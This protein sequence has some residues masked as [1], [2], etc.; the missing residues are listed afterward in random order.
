MLDQILGQE[1][2]VAILKRA[3][4]TDSLGHAYLFSGDEGVGKETVAR[5]VAQALLK[6]GGPLSELHVLGGPESIK[7]DQIRAVRQKAALAASGS[8]VWIILDAERLTPEAANAFLK[9]LE[10]P[11]QGTY[12]FLT[13]TKVQSILPTI[14]S[15]CQHLA[16]RPLSE[17]QVCAWLAQ[18]TGRTPDDDQVRTVAKLSQGSLGRAWAYWEGALL[19]E[20]AEVIEKLKRIPHASY[21]EVLGLSQRWPEDRQQV[22]QELQLFL[23][24]HRDLLLVKNGV[25]LPLYNPSYERELQAISELYSN[26]ELLKIMDTI[27]EMGKAIAGNGRVRFCLGYLFL[28]MKRGALT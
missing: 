4:S 16:F 2:P 11:P 7:V 9:T 8:S 14:L 3:L 28:M 13:T 23:E 18:K 1:V 20:R 26:Q 6:K 17:E 25:D 27:M 15:R 19:E 10:E 5:A 24:W 21:P 22:L 12:F